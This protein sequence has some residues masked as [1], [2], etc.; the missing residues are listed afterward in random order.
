MIGIGDDQFG[1]FDGFAAHAVFAQCAGYD[2]RGKAFAEAGNGVESARREL[3]EQRG[4]F[5]KPLC[6]ARFSSIR[7]GEAFRAFRE[8]R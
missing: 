5:A 3:A 6:F 1:G 7:S 2:R 8:S 4:T